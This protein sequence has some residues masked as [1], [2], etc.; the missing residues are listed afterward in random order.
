MCQTQWSLP[1]I[2]INHLVGKFLHHKCTWFLIKPR[3]VHILR[4]SIINATICS[5]QIHN[6]ESHCQMF[7]YP[8]ISTYEY[9]HTTFWEHGV[10]HDDITHHR[11]I[12]LVGHR[13][14]FELI[15]HIPYLTLRGMLWWSSIVMSC[16]KLALFQWMHFYNL[17]QDCSNSIA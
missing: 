10:I 1:N 2:S 17:G 13:S 14:Y 16:G 8:R 12:T 11:E 3:N 4:N 6:I 15:K 9:N 5:F 7:T